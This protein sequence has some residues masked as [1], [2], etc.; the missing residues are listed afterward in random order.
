MP[1]RSASRRWNPSLV[2]SCLAL[3]VALSGTAYAAGLAPGSVHTKAL[4]KGAVTGKKIKTAAVGSRAIADRTIRLHDLGGDPAGNV[5]RQVNKTATVPLDITIPVGECR[6]LGL[7]LF[8]PAPAG[9]LGSMVVG[10]I[11]T[12]TGGP[13]FN[14]VGFVVPTLVTETSQGGAVLQLGVC[15]GSSTQTIPAGSIVTWSLVAP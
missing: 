7:T 11:T 6:S 12:S 1:D 2:I 5:P 4:A 10:K 13:V 9:I 14:N 3:L 15:A 8:N